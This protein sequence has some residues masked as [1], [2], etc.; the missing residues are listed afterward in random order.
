MT[1]DQMFIKITYI[2]IC[3]KTF[4]C[5][6]ALGS[7]SNLVKMLSE[8]DVFISNYIIVDPEIYQLWIEGYTSEYL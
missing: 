2:Y 6:L 7:N 3:I 5:T 8:L 4:R 1:N